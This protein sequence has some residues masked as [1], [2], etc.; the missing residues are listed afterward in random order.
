MVEFPEDRTLQSGSWYL[1]TTGRKRIFLACP[2]CGQII[3]I[4]PCEVEIIEDG[5]LS[6]IIDCPNPICD[7]TDAVRLVGWKKPDSSSHIPAV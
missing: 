4:E 3:S 6:K 1:W 5:C 2:M 7:F